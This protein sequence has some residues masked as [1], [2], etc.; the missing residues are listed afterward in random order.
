[1]FFCIIMLSFKSVFKNNN[2]L[3]SLDIQE[4]IMPPN[5]VLSF[6]FTLIFYKVVIKCKINFQW[7][8]S[9]RLAHPRIVP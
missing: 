3:Y 4:L 9:Q 6:N 8:Q 5:L 1:M 2:S 7:T